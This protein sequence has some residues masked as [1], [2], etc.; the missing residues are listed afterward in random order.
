MG[1]G[2]DLMRERGVH[3][4]VVFR[5]SPENQNDGKTATSKFHRSL[6]ARGPARIFLSAPALRGGQPED[7]AA[8][9]AQWIVHSVLGARTRPKINDRP[10]NNSR[11]IPLGYRTS[12]PVKSPNSNQSSV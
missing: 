1:G 3:S 12:G 11:A 4:W 8:M 5:G 9:D 7:S 6:S 2:N 10:G